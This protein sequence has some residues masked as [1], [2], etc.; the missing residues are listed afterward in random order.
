M[1]RLLPSAQFAFN[2]VVVRIY[3]DFKAFINLSLRLSAREFCKEIT[4]QI[5][6]GIQPIK[7]ICKSKQ[8]IP[9]NSFPLKRN[10]RKGKKIAISVI[11][12]KVQKNEFKPEF[13]YG[14]MRHKMMLLAFCKAYH[15]F[16][17]ADRI[18]QLHDE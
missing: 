6:A 7:V 12:V 9:V 5:A 14:H 11:R 13:F 2:A 18:N 17:M 8:I 4:A 1:L 16:H 15:S 10:E 3:L